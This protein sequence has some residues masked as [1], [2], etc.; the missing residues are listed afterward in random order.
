M[1]VL[2]AVH[3]AHVTLFASALALA[4]CAADPETS[5]PDVAAAE[6]DLAAKA[7][8]HWF[9]G[10][11]LPALESPSATVSLT[12][13][14]VRVTGYLA[15]GTYVPQMP[16]LRTTDEAGRTRVDLVYPIATARPG[17]SN[18][19]P[20]LYT[21]S[22]AKPYRPHGAA[23][24]QEEGWHDVP[25]GGFPFLPYDGGIALHGPITDKDNKSTQNQDVWYLE[26]GQVSGGCNRM[27]GEHVVE[28][29]HV[30]GVDMR[31]VYDPN[32]F[33]RV[34]AAPKVRVVKD[35]DTFG[36]R[37]IDVDYPTSTGATRPAKVY[38]DERVEMFG[39]WLASETPDGKDLPPDMKWQGGVSGAWYSFG[40]HVL[41]N[42]VCS[43]PK[44]DLRA[45]RTFASRWG[46]T[47]PA[48]FCEKKACIVSE[49]RAGRD[50]S[51]CGL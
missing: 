51:T 23:L 31:R 24:T 47:L 44:A 20:G 38:G 4:A 36:G 17:K 49:L 3:A 40:E 33:V 34:A 21:M 18:S 14:T 7:D 13:H 50:A 35:Y 45:L 27:M 22:M 12:G 16:H 29:A 2:R 6:D 8:D 37:F 15:A 19:R 26:R 48:S 5:A 10:G 32:T 42:M 39:S 25:W 11:P 1:F 30:M 28:L 9:Y 43:V 41:P 46:G